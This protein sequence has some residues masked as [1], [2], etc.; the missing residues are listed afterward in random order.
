[1]AVADAV[2]GILYFDPQRRVEVQNLR[3][4]ARL[5][6]APEAELFIDGGFALGLR[7]QIAEPEWQ[8]AGCG[9]AGDLVVAL[10][11][12][13]ENREDLVRRLRQRG[14]APRSHGD[15]DLVAE[16]WRAD[17]MAA[18]AALEGFFSAVVWHRG[19]RELVLVADRCAGVRTLYHAPG[20]GFLAFGSTLKSVLAHPEVPRRLDP[21]AL[22]DLLVVRHAIGPR[23]LVAGVA[24]MVAGTC[25]RVSAGASESHTY[26]RRRPWVDSGADLP[27]LERAYFA[28]LVAAVA[29]RTGAHGSDVMLSGGVDSAALV[30]LL[31]RL[32]QRRIRTFSVH[33]GD[34]ERSDR[35][36]SLAIARLF[37]TEHHSLDDLDATCL[38]ALPEIVWHHEAPA[39]DVHPTFWLARRMAA[40]S[41]A[42]LTGHGNDLV[43]GS[44]APHWLAGAGARRLVPMVH[45]LH[46]LTVRRKLARRALRALLPSAPRTDYGLLRRLS[47]FRGATGDP[48][49]DFACLDEGLFG[50]QRVYREIGKLLLD[51]HALRCLMPFT[52]ARLT[53]I[54]ESVPPRAR[55]RR[56]ASGAPELK[57][58]FKDLMQREDVL[59]SEVIYRQ[60]TWM[61]SPTADWLRGP[62][63]AVVEGLLLGARASDRGLFERSRIAQ[64]VTEHRS[65]RADHAALL[66]LLVA[67]EL[68]QRLF[69]DPET[70]LPPRF[71]LRSA[72]VG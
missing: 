40:E 55:W 53:R 37:A 20:P 24:T 56:R 25:V 21:V 62:L 43:W 36:A 60:K 41:D 28:A 26:W 11:G 64:L 35:A 66:M 19:R 50:D 52:D 33:I 57:A 58:F 31:R 23:T 3:R 27:E 4:V 16:L 69:L 38:D 51:A 29:R 14:L 46:Y 63:G 70:P 17:G 10:T 34:A 2:F 8:M 32:E 22:E 47:A 67:L 68:W 13:I 7:R 39:V 48:L 44:M 5:L 72:D 49:A 6:G 9:R 65:G 61:H 12:E 15:A 71:D 45:E 18:A 1:M 30:S 59:P 54:A 42:I